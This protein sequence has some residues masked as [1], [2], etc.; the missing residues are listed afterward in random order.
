M[1]WQLSSAPGPCSGVWNI[2]YMAHVYLIKGETL[3]T[4]LRNRNFFVL[5]KLDPDMAA[6]RNAREMVPRR[7]HTPPHTSHPPH[8]PSNIPSHPFKHPH[9]ASQLC[10]PPIP[11]TSKNTHSTHP[12][13]DVRKLNCSRRSCCFPNVKKKT[14][15]KGLASITRAPVLHSTPCPAVCPS[16]I[17]CPYH[18]P[19]LWPSPSLTPGCHWLPRCPLSLS[20]P[21][22]LPKIVGRV[23]L[24]AGCSS[25]PPPP[26]ATFQEGPSFSL[27]VS[28][29][30][31]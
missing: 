22:V 1:E 21:A 31:N 16:E 17:Y 4:E 3:R 5:E 2:P 25:P 24:N 6:C 23:C 12:G 20:R 8:T 15:R 13:N 30:V 19:P 10:T 26:H 18:A 7:P 28:L 11:L 29:P 14:P 9:S 27:S